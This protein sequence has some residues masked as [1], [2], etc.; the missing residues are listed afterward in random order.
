[1]DAVLGSDNI[2]ALC[3]SGET[4]MGVKPL[5]LTTKASE[6]RAPLSKEG[7]LGATPSS[8]I[9][10]TQP[11]NILALQ[12]SM[13][14]QAVQNLLSSS[15]QRAISRSVVSGVRATPIAVPHREKMEAMFGYSQMTR[16]HLISPPSII[17]S[18]SVPRL[19]RYSLHS[20]YMSL[21]PA[22]S[23]KSFAAGNPCCFRYSP[24]NRSRP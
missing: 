13:G 3:S 18:H 17:V 7:E 6:E 22:S 15:M 11:S 2:N 23:H 5:L 14:N 8:H 9:P 20:R 1:M 10:L 16:N 19:G 4:S 12:R 21:M 24:A